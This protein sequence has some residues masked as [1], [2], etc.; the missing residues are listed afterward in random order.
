MVA[1]DEMHGAGE[2]RPAYAALQ[3]WLER[4]PPALMETRRRQAELFFRRI[5]ITFNV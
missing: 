1:F 5:G 2:V 3:A 4:S